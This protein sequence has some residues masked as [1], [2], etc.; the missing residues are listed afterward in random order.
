MTKSDFFI[1]INNVVHDL[2]IAKAASEINSGVR[3]VDPATSIFGVKDFDMNKAPIYPQWFF[4]ARLGQPRNIDFIELRQLSRSPWVQ[5]VLSTIKKQVS[6]TPWDLVNVD[7]KDNN[8]YEEEKKVIKDFFDNINDN[9]DTIGDL[10]S[11]H[12]TDLG[13]VDAAVSTNIFTQG[14]YDY[15][16]VDILDDWGNSIGTETRYVL[17]PFG[18]REL[19]GVSVVD[20][21]SYLIQVDRYKRTMAYFQYS[22]QNP[23]ANPIRFEKAE[24]NYLLS[25][26]RSYDVYGFSPVQS[27][28]QVLELL[29]QSTR[30]NKEFFARNAIPDAMITI[31]GANKASLDA[32][33]DEWLKSAQG[34]PHKLMFN[35]MVDGKIDVFNLSNKDMEW[36]N[37][38]KWFFHLVFAVFGLSPAEVGFYEDVNRSAQEGQERVSVKNA[39][40]PYYDLFSKLANNLIKEKL[41]LEDVPFRFEFQPED[42]GQEKI[43]FD[44]DM[45]EIETGTLTV[46]EYRVSR[47][48]SPVEGGDDVRNQAPKE[49]DDLG[50]TV[51]DTSKVY[52]SVEFLNF[53]SER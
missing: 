6:I 1:P 12:V 11:M 33:K 50:L 17:K 51:E 29:I 37:G 13:E 25:N 48:R 3:K 18:E 49:D 45:K 41:Q 16:E 52:K 36:L 47:G 40:K 7:D 34:N 53:L 42:S 10:F 19:Y 39:I 32:M 30:F 35:N 44:N 14:S 28:Q 20:P 31:P 8:T 38:Q 24:V 4:T 2:E 5:M 27:I 22:W 46:N 15:G 26:R 21:T 43:A 23:H 9:A